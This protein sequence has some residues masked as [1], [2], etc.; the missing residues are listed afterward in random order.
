[1]NATAAEAG[2][3]V[4]R[5]ETFFLGRTEGAGI[6]RDAFGRTQRRCVIVTQ[7]ASHGAYQAIHFDET[8]TYDDGEVDTWRWALTVGPDGD[9][10]A[11]EA[12]AGSG[13]EGRRSGEDYVLAFHRPSGRARG[14]LAPRFLTRFTLLTADVALRDVRISMLGAP[15]GQMLAMHRRI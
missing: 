4:F 13:L 9:Y 5:P 7:G 8:F 15:M 12:V 2:D 1:M 14:V 11:A 10:V 6:V 3:K